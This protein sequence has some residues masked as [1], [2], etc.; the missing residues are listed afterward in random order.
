MGLR[1]TKPPA[2][3]NTIVNA[4]HP[5]STMAKETERTMQF[6]DELPSLPLPSL[7][8]TLEQYVQSCEPLLEPS[9]LEHTKAVCH[10]FLH[11]VGPQLQAILQER[12]DTER[13]WIEEWWE[14]FAYLQPRYPSAIN[15]NWYGVLPG[16]WGPRDMS[17]CEAASIFTHAI[18]KFRKN[19]LEYVIA[20]F[21]RLTN[22]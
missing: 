20:V 5:L 22:G 18:L 6:Q 21:F 14:T 13:N 7:E 16:N 17:Q 11:G 15:I 9:E 3:V 8:Q 2:A 10:D 12:A 19:L 4:S 1:S